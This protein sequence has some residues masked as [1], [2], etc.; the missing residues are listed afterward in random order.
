MCEPGEGLGTGDV[1]NPQ[2]H[3]CKHCQQIVLGMRKQCERPSWS[4]L[5]LIELLKI[6]FSSFEAGS[7]DGC[8]FF[9]FLDVGSL[10]KQGQELDIRFHGNDSAA[11]IIGIWNGMAEELQVY[12]PRGQCSSQ[13]E[14]KGSCSRRERIQRRTID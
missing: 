3:E 10:I 4:S 2:L 1:P 8:D 6:P 12:A 9:K 13:R 7:R 5:T 14:R 11:D